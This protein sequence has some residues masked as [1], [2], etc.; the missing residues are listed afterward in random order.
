MANVDDIIA[1]EEGRLSREQE[2]RFFQRMVNTGEVWRLQG[3]YGRRAQEL[4]N[5]GEIDYPKKA[6]YDA[7]GNKIP[8]QSDIAKQFGKYESAKKRRKMRQVS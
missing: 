4:L 3:M 8:T 1:W 7:Y 6:T 5:A 2:R